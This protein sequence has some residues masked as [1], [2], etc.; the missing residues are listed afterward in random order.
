MH[1]YSISEFWILCALQVNRVVFR[2]FLEMQRRRRENP[3][4]TSRRSSIVTLQRRDVW[5]KAVKVKER[6]N[7]AMFLQFLYQNY[8][9]TRDLIFGMI[10]GRTDEERKTK[11]EQP[12]RSKRLVFFY[13]SSQAINDL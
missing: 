1:Y 3:A 13:F 2:S 8:K 10:E 6:P 9:I 7:V 5:S 11:H 12:E 4:A